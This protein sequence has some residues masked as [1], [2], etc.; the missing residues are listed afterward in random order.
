MD[1]DGGSYTSLRSVRHHFTTPSS[2]HHLSPRKLNPLLEEEDP[3]PDSPKKDSF[4]TFARH[5]T[6]AP[7]KKYDF[8]Q[9]SAFF[10]F[11]FTKINYYFVLFRG[12]L[13]P[14]LSFLYFKN[15]LV[16]AFSGAHFLK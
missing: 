1:L 11:L 10:Q 9:F 2:H 3:K 16:C 13:L 7:P 8:I 14:I 5:M 12:S 6:E 4:W 15:Q